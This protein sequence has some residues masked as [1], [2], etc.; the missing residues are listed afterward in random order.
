MP[1]F[2]L[3]KRAI[4]IIALLMVTV[5]CTTTER[6]YDQWLDTATGKPQWV[7]QG[8]QTSKSIQGRFFWG[9]G[10]ASAAGEFSRQADTANQRAKDEL[11]KMVERFIE[12]I[13]RDYIASGA[14]AQAGFLEHQATRYI[15]EMTAIVLPEVKIMEHWVDQGG[16]KIF[17][18]AELEYNRMVSLL[19]GSSQVNP[20]FKDYLRSKGESV[21]DH[22]A[23]RH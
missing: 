1:N 23:T 13:S 12:V 9:V 6:R 8:T 3:M 22:I 5:A 2:Q 15:N 10:E 11:Q 19:A 18:I 20:G 21:F 16:R 17:A 7:L 4:S 14:A